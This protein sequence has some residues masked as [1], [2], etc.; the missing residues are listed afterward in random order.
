MEIVVKDG[1]SEKALRTLKRKLGTEG[2]FKAMNQH[3]C[4]VRPGD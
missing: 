4:F 1:K 3:E 2:V